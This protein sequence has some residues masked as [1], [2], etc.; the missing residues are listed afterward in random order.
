MMI[1][2][3]VEKLLV[4]DL[5]CCTRGTLL[6]ASFRLL[7]LIENIQFTTKSNNHDTK[8]PANFQDL[9]SCNLPNDELSTS[10]SDCHIA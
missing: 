6:K 1:L 5:S 8:S 9:L 3:P 10:E 4:I 2:F 7:Y